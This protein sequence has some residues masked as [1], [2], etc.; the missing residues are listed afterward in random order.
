MPA[1]VSGT[2]ILW[3]PVP[4][5][6]PPRVTQFDSRSVNVYRPGESDAADA[7]MLV[8]KY[9][10]APPQGKTKDDLLDAASKGLLEVWAI[11]A[12]PVTPPPPP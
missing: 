3:E 10:L 12:V 1:I 9:I 5:A 7:T 8:A 2:V 11:T 6:D 4:N